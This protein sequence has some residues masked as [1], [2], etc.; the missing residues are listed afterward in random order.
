M[1]LV[2]RRALPGMRRWNLRT[3]SGAAV[4]TSVRRSGSIREAVRGMDA[5]PGASRDGFTAS[6]RIDPEGRD[7]AAAAKP[8]AVLKFHR[9]LSQ[10][11]D[12]EHSV[13][14]LPSYEQVADDPVLYAH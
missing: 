5:A 8:E 9:R 4:A 12:R 1:T 10:P 13:I 11:A 3:V 14:R 7:A 6:S 2:S